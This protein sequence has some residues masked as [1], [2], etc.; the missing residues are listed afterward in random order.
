MRTSSPLGIVAVATAMPGKE[1]ALRTAQ[2]TLVAETVKE[3][4]CIRY[5]LHQSL[6]DSNILIFV[7]TW[8]NEAAWRAH[9][10]SPAMKQ[11][12]ASGA[13]GLFEDFVLYRTT[14]VAGG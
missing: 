4:G 6:E 12:E 11:F 3:P 10:E 8:A 14:R 7:E 5:E 13:D 9:L 1:T 2:E